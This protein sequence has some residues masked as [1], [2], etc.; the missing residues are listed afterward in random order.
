LIF[1]VDDGSAEPPSE[2]S[3]RG[4]TIISTTLGN[5]ENTFRSKLHHLD[6]RWPVLQLEGIDQR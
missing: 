4:L 3:R 2:S 6:A 5:G 1:S